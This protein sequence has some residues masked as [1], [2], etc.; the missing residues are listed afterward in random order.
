[1]TAILMKELRGRMRGWTA[2]VLLTAYVTLL[3]FISLAMLGLLDD[4]RVVY[5]P[6]MASM[7]VNVF[8]IL[9]IL[10]TALV[11]LIA[12]ALT[13]GAIAGEKDRQTFDLLLSTRLS[14]FSIVAGKLVTS[15]AFVI[16][17]ILASVPLLSLVFLFGGVP[18]GLVVRT[19]AVQ[20]VT[21]LIMGAGGLFFSTIVR[22]TT[23][24]TAL[25]IVLAVVMGLGTVLFG[26]LSPAIGAQRIP[27]NEAPPG[28]ILVTD[29]PMGMSIREVKLE[30]GGTQ[31]LLPAAMYLNPGVAIVSAAGVVG[32]SGGIIPGELVQEL[33]KATWAPAWAVY[34]VGGTGLA[35]LFFCGAWWRLDPRPRGRVFGGL[36]RR[37]AA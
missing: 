23:A 31:A 37:R 9:S 19:I 36:Q 32:V 16:L 8:G 33:N 30:N 4:Q 5:G 24:A 3:A 11:M 28:T 29:G 6:Q 13:A 10:Q 1:M 12:P 35:A 14:A 18:A 15:L 21:A 25:G 7:G 20:M 27:R 2:P 17:L 22:R 34:L 26:A